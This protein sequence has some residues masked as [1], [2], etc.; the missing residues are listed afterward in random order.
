MAGS[1]RRYTESTTE[2]TT[3]LLPDSAFP[4]RLGAVVR[5][6]GERRVRQ[7]RAEGRL[8]ERTTPTSSRQVKAG[9]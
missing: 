3:V 6:G 2:P 4:G 1:A 7:V 9:T 8:G 5:L